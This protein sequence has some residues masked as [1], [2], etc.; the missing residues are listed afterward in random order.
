MK[1]L[2]THGC[3]ALYLLF[4][5]SLFAQ[6][7]V[8]PSNALQ[9]YLKK[10]DDTYGWQIRDSFTINDVK[11]YNLLLTSQK[12]HGYT[13][14]HQLTIFVPQ[15]IKYDA[16]LLFITGGSNKKDTEIPNWSGKDDRFAMG[17][18]Q[19]ATANGAV[20]NVLRQVPNQPIFDSLKEDAAISYTL[21]QFKED[22][23]YTWP[24]LFPMV[25]SAVHAMDAVQDFCNTITGHKMNRF[26][27]SGASKRGWT[28]WLTGAN[29]PRV[30]AI[31]PMVI[32]ILN[33]P[34]NLQH[35]I[36]A[37][38]DYSVEIQ[39]YVKLGIVQGMNAPGGKD[40]VTMIDPYSYRKTLTMPKMIFIGTNDPYWVI[41]NTKNYLK[42]IP[43][44][45]MIHYTPNAGHD[46]NN[47]ITAFPALSAFFG[48]AAANGKYPE[49]T[50]TTA[51]KKKKVRIKVQASPD[52]LTGASIWYASSKD[53]DFRDEKWQEKE[54]GYAPDGTV[55]VTEALPRSGFYSFYVELKY[56]NPN[57]GSYT[58]CT[59]AFMTNNKKIL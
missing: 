32:D 41:D 39:D 6:E 17:M 31:G 16:A 42:E 10:K 47:G 37:Y 30:V 24:L 36:D 3:I 58:V 51:V 12:W 26:V 14:K 19:I 45:N 23:D 40:I 29:D 4:T 1:R 50:W 20:V 22:G 27:V 44:K 35:Q 57:G 5:T 48:I 59:R 9:Q 38:G 49:Y 53:M 54:A 8:T 2:F 11:G 43:G 25:K 56:K 52:Q 13:W 15:K 46:L 34:V 55:R 18:S 33:M 21:H 28:T 7:T